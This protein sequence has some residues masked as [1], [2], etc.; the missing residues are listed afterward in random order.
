MN[1]QAAGIDEYLAPLPAWQQDNLSV[2]RSII[3]ELLPDITE[4]IK[5][6]VPVFKDGS[7]M[8]FAMAAFK[9]HTKFNFI[10]NGASLSDLDKLFNNGFDSKK[11][12]A[13]DL[14]EEEKIDVAKL[15]GLIDAAIAQAN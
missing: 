9:E 12:R 1:G 14:R 6:G 3:H 7:T 13:I 15:A 11:S 2:L 10:H 4:D 5:W 8:L